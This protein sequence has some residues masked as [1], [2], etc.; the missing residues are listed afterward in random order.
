MATLKNTCAFSIFKA[1]AN[2]NVTQPSVAFLYV[3]LIICNSMQSVT[4]T[5]NNSAPQ[6]T[7]NECRDASAFVTL[8]LL[9]I[10]SF[11]LC[12]C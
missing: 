9:N 12:T 5:T 3:N 1:S 2:G 7:Y 11:T 4:G 6:H 8:H 10:A